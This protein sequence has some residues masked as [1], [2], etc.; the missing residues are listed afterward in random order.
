MQENFKKSTKKIVRER[1]RERE[2]ENL[3]FVRKNYAQNGRDSDEFIVRQ[4]TKEETKIKEDKG[5]EEE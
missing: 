1:E 2:R 5:K 3:C 4:C